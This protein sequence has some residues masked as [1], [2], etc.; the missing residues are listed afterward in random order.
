LSCAFQHFADLFFVAIRHRG[1][2]RLLVFEIAIDKPYANPSLGADIVHAGLVKAALGEA[3]QGGI[4]DLG[5]PVGTRFHLGLRHRFAKMNER[6]FIV[7]R[8]AENLDGTGRQPEKTW[9]LLAFR[10]IL[11]GV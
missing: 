9:T 10:R 6:S 7:K 1:N 5:A 2:D 11:F 4:E 3:D 8:L